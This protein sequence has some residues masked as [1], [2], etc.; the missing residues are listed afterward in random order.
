MSLLCLWWNVSYI[1]TRWP[2]DATHSVSNTRAADETGPNFEG[3]YRVEW[4]D[5]SDVAFSIRWLSDNYLIIIWF[6]EFTFFNFKNCYAPFSLGSKAQKTATAGTQRRCRKR[7]QPPSDDKMTALQRRIKS[8]RYLAGVTFH[9]PIVTY[10]IYSSDTTI[11]D[12]QDIMKSEKDDCLFS[13]VLT[14]GSSPQQSISARREQV[15][16]S[17]AIGNGERM[18]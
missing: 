6:R 2:S 5:D 12:S 4:L 8:S 3:P 7:T 11:T 13:L 14:A 18:I 9:P 16:F 15:P 10:V 17:M 1:Q